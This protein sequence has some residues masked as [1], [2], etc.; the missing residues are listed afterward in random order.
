M[1]HVR[2]VIAAWRADFNAARPHSSLEYLTPA[3][4]ADS[5]KTQWP[6][7]LHPADRSAPMSIA[8]AAQTRKS[9]HLIP[10][11]NG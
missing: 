8:H 3:A 7:T 4:Y 6:S 1:G 5:L 2:A 10:V 11:A 9:Q